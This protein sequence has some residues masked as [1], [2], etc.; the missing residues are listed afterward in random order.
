M[1]P[2]HLTLVLGL[3]LLIFVE[4]VMITFFYLVIKYKP[5]IKEERANETHA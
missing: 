4:L 3:I 5:N 2:E 1:I